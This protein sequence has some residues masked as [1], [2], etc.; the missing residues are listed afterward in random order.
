M[1]DKLPPKMRQFCESMC[2]HDIEVDGTN[3][4]HAKFGGAGAATPTYHPRSLTSDLEQDN[5]AVIK[6]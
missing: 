4:K 5:L 6:P 3:G 2:L 1:K